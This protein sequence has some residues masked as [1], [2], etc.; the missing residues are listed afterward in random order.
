MEVSLVDFV[1]E[2]AG[3][4]AVRDRVFGEE[5]GVPNSI[6]WDG[7][8][9]LCQHVIVRD[10]DDKVVGTGRLAPCGK[11]GRLSVLKKF[12]GQG[13]GLKL[14]RRLLSVARESQLSEVYLHAQA[15]AV[16]FYEGEGFEIAGT[17]FFEAGM[18][19][20][21]MSKSLEKNKDE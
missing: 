21:Q 8:D 5:Q 12:R 20:L 14:L 13:V 9:G 4:R 10:K 18:E 16:G 17:P 3:I 15:K 1:E 11:I 7:N 2:E 19:H 6:N